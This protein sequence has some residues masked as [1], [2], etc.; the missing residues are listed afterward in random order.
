MADRTAWVLFDGDN[1]LWHI[2]ALYDHAREELV[3]CIDPSG[4]NAAD[5]EAFQRA[6]DKR[7]FETLGYSATRFAKSFENT[8]RMFVPGAADAQREHVRSLAL[9][10]FEHPAPV[11]RDALQVLS[12]LRGSHRLALITA[13]ERWVQEKRVAAFP[14]RDMFQEIRIVERKTETVFRRITADLGIAV[15]DLWV[16]GDSLRS[17]VM[18]ALTA[19]LNAILIANHN[20]IEVERDEVRPHNLRVVDRLGDVPLIINP[21]V[22]ETPGP[23]HS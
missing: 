4:E 8:F 7:M 6:E 10:V 21:P 18:P 3:R 9:A 15:R 12:E 5:I 19:G 22:L 23:A 2:E 20:W 14:Y 17:D 1:T 11:D 13:G 16:V